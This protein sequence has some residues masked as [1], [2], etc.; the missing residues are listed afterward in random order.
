[1]SEILVWVRMSFLVIA[2]GGYPLAATFAAPVRGVP[3]DLWADK[4]LGQLDFSEITINQADNKSLFNAYSVTVDNAH[5]RMYIYDSGNS[6]VLGVSNLNALTSEQG[7]DMVLGQPDFNHASCNVD[8]NLQNYP[9]LTPANDHCLCGML[10][11]QPSTS[12]GGSTGNM[13]V[14]GQGNLYVPDYFNNR[15]LR[16]DWPTYTGEPASHVWG[17]Q[18]FT[19]IQ[20]NQGGAV[21]SSTLGFYPN[22]NVWIY[23]AGVS[24]DAWGNLWVADASNNRVLRFPN[25]S[26]VAGGV[27]ALTPDVVLGQPNF[28][29]N[30]A[31]TGLT[32]LQLPSSVRVDPAGRVYVGDLPVHFTGRVTIFTPTGATAGGVPTYNNGMAATAAVTQNLEY[33][34]GMEWDPSGDLWVTDNEQLLL[35]HF[36][37]TPV[38]SSSIRKV[39]LKDVPQPPSTETCGTP[40][41]VT[42]DNPAWFTDNTGV[43]Y[44]PWY[45]CDMRGAVGVD[46]AGNVYTGSNKVQDVWRFPAPIPDPVPGITHSADLRLFAPQ[47]IGLR[48]TMGSRGMFNVQGVAVASGQ[49]VVA[50]NNRLMFWNMPTGPQGLSNGQSADG[51]TGN[52]NAFLATGNEYGRIREDQASPQQHLWALKNWGNVAQVA[53]YNLP[54]TNNAAPAYPLISSPLPVLGGGSVG[55]SVM[56]GIAPDASGTHVWVSDPL[57]NRV[58]RVRNPFTAPTVDIILGQAGASATLCNQTGTTTDHCSSP[59]SATS[60]FRPGAVR[61]DHQGDLYVSDTTIELTGNYRMLRWDA[62]Q[63]PNNNSTCLYGISAAAVY[64]TNGNFNS[65]NPADTAN[66]MAAPFEPG[67]LSDDSVMVCGM[68]PY[69]GSRFPIVFNNPRAGDHPVTHLSD[70]GSL[71]YASTFDAQDNLYVVDSNRS[72]VMI[73]YAPFPPPEPTPTSTVTPSP[74]PTPTGTWYSPT[75][76]PTATYTPTTPPTVG[77]CQSDRVYTGVNG[78]TG[79]AV[80][81]Q[82]LFVSDP[83]NNRVAIYDKNQPGSPMTNL[84][85]TNHPG[86]GFSHPSGVALD[87]QGHL[88]VTDIGSL[89]VYQFNDAPGY[90]LQTS[91]DGTGGAPAVSGTMV[92]PRAV[93]SNSAGTTVAVAMSESHEIRV[94]NRQG[95]LFIPI[96]KLTM[97]STP[98]F[99]PLGLMGDDSGNLFVV[100]VANKVLLRFSG[101]NYS[102]V[103]QITDLSA[104]VNQPMYWA[105][106]TAGNNYVTDNGGKFLVFDPSWNSLYSCVSANGLAYN[107]PQGIAVDVDG[108]IYVS[109]QYSN[110]AVRIAACNKTQG[111]PSPTASPSPTSTLTLTPTPTQTA[112]PSV[113]GTPTATSSPTSSWSMTP[114]PTQT[115]TPTPSWTPT[116]TPSPTWTPTFTPT[117]THTL[118][119]TVT[120]TP[121]PTG[122]ATATPT[123]PFP[124]RPVICQPNPV[125]SGDTVR[126]WWIPRGGRVPDGLYLVTVAD[127]VLRR[128]DAGALVSGQNFIDLD[129]KDQWGRP[130]ANGLYFVVVEQAGRSDVGKLVVLR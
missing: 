10:Q 32:G 7:A 78:S 56:H 70:F 106:D 65:S 63:L 3:G 123:P 47:Q 129:L 67:F 29:Q 107:Q 13:S 114:T 130:L 69:M 103:N 95:G 35:F 41:T 50:D 109:D 93:W 25:T 101:V 102:V 87:A 23:V 53:I 64:G 117:S 40:A 51:F 8:S 19:G 14:D 76:P 80:D 112:T 83:G 59:P 9:S 15:V 43:S 17:Q 16:Y 92:Y 44:P 128:I 105:R 54:I 111:S 66:G 61:M 79:L 33:V 30:Y 122:S 96:L 28:T 99:Y 37:F 85:N 71:P 91:F 116:P 121:T 24:V 18:D 94:F 52:V 58:F 46:Q 49:V 74:T 36:N 1:M 77:C 31:G 126:V 124:E 45:M 27:P 98:T 88:Y 55:W 100:D 4:I 5:H 118:T 119:W 57:N 90:P 84:D 22:T 86:L 42:G 104:L 38:F 89:K 125:R 68:N 21:S 73:Y 11:G 48:N 120:S 34:M 26:G 82:S 113:T 127:R 75:V 39:L 12:E 81:P 62:G 20:Y 115:L 2:L 60:L 6:R 72:R 108:H 110:R 97:P